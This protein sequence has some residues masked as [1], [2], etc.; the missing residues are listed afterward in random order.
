MT[1]APWSG[2]RGLRHRAD[3][4]RPRVQLPT[5]RP[6]EWGQGVRDAAAGRAGALQDTVASCSRGAFGVLLGAIVLLALVASLLLNTARGE[7]AFRLAE[8]QEQLTAAQERRS[9]VSGDVARLSSPERI[10]GR[11]EALGM[12]PAGAVGYVDPQRGEI[13]GEAERAEAPARPEGSSAAS[14]SRTSRG[15]TEKASS[16]K[17]ERAT[18]A[19]RKKKT[20]EKTV[21][22]QTSEREPAQ[23]GSTRSSSTSRRDG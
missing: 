17:N 1:T 20:G 14:G 21:R 7:G 18:K 15:S 3:V 4:D 10:A 5:L 2:P 23:A 22:E 13:I 16:A 12:V 9:S 19:T 6:A 8:S 11:A